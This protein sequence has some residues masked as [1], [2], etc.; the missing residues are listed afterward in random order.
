MSFSHDD[1]DIGFSLLNSD[2]KPMVPPLTKRQQ[3]A[4][5]G[6]V[7]WTY[8]GDAKIRSLFPTDCG[9]RFYSESDSMKLWTADLF[10]VRNILRWW[11]PRSDFLLNEEPN[12]RARGERPLRTRRDDGAGTIGPGVRKHR[13]IY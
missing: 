7:D 1:F 6:G 8:G 11:R 10:A 9:E 5:R 3:I 13:A 12:R 2:V 4:G